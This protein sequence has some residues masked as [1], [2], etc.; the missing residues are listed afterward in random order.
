VSKPE[1]IYSVYLRDDLIAH[2]KTREV[3]DAIIKKEMGNEKLPFG[4][5]DYGIVERYLFTSADQLECHYVTINLETLLVMSDYVSLPEK[6][7]IEP[8]FITVGSTPSS[9]RWIADSLLVMGDTLELA[10]RSGLAF[11]S[12]AVNKGIYPADAITLPPAT[13][14]ILRQCGNAKVRAEQPILFCCQKDHLE[15]T[16]K[17][18]MLACRYCEQLWLKDG[19]KLVKLE[20]SFEY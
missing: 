7:D 2:A 20:P 16:S 8:R 15:K 13:L 6:E 1:V 17:D 9:D 12:R 11:L 3:A 14:E 5:Y 18:N 10:Y 4:A 19:K